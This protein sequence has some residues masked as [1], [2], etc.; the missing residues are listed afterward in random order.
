MRQAFIRGPGIWASGVTRFIVHAVVTTV[1][2][3]VYMIRCVGSW[4]L[5]GKRGV[6]WVLDALYSFT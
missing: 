3:H 5:H 1:M 6:A 2:R 4:E